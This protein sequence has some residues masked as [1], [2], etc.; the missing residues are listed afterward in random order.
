MHTN[1]T[2]RRRTARILMVLVL[3]LIVIV[4]LFPIYW[5]FATSLEDSKRAFSFP[6]A[7][8]PQ[9]TLANFIGA[10]NLAP[11]GR[12]LLNSLIVGSATTIGT[13]VVGFMAAYALVHMLGRR[14]SKLVFGIALL[15]MMVPFYAVIIPDYIIVRDINLLNTYAAQ[16]LPFIGGGFAIFLF[17]QFIMG[18]PSEYRDAARSDGLGNWGYMWR[19]LFPNLRPAFVTIGIYT[20]ILSWNSFLWPLIVT[21]DSS[22]Q[23]IQVGLQNV[24]TTANGTDFTLLAAAAAITAIPVIILYA[25]FQRQ[26]TDS[27]AN[28]GLK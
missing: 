20:F 24:V 9:G 6:G 4:A 8:I 10:W 27:V 22:V 12:L 13:L 2:L 15:T 17:R 23:P 3:L 11:W 5:I 19:I 26:V 14:S 16:V 21:S 18:F 7:L 1:R 25:V 28:I